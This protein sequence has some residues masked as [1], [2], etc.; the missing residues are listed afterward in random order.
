MSLEQS[1]VLVRHGRPEVDPKVASHDWRLSDAGRNAAISLAAKLTDFAF[2][3]VLSSPEEKALGTAQA[4]GGVLGLEV[5]VDADLAEHSRRSAG[6]LAAA[7]F[8]AG[9]A[10][11]F[12]RPDELV[13]GDETADAAHARFSGAVERNRRNSVAADVLVVSH[14]TVMSLYVSRLMG[15]DPFP[16]WRSLAMPTVIVL[17]G[18]H[19]KVIGVEEG[20]V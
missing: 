15:F 13:F 16:F 6:F 7:E 18:S 19:M 5:S 8:E 12:T 10:R 20:T 3:H 2:Q 11:L 17:R 4:V 1:I 14:G 9:I